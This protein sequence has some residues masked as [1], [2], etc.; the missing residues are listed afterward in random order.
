[1]V[2][3]SISLIIAQLLPSTVNSGDSVYHF[4][5]NIYRQFFKKAI[6]KQSNPINS[7]NSGNLDPN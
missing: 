5:N 6:K 7:D 2:H 3:V 4:N 1:M